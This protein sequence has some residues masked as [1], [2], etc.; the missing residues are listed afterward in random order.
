MIQDDF[1]WYWINNIHGVSREKIKS[2]LNTFETPRDVYNAGEKLLLSVP[3]IGKKSVDSII[4]SKKQE[5]LFLEYSRMKDKGIKITYPGKEDYP[6]KLLNIYDYPYILYYKGKLL[7]DRPAVSVIGARNCTEYGK[8]IA[9]SFSA[10][11]SQMGLGVIS[12]MALG[13]DTQAH[14]GALDAGG[15]TCAVLGCG[16]DVCYPRSNIGM[17]EEIIETGCILSEYPPGT[18]PNP[19][20]FPVRNRIISA[21]SDAVVV[22]EARAKSGSLITVDA[23]MEYNKDVY[24]V[25]GRIG[26]A[27]SEG[28]LI[29]LKEAG[30]IITSPADIFNTNSINS[31][32]NSIKKNDI[33]QNN[34]NEQYN[35]DVAK[36]KFLVYSQINLFPTS[37]EIIIR[38]SGLLTAVVSQFLIE[39]EIEGLIKEVSKNYY[40]RTH[41]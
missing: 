1:Y 26:D 12:G 15:Y 10:A 21:L 32:V 31:Y 18:A 2:L 30:Y 40:V 6:E 13:I 9:R 25:P 34:F 3:D 7:L 19:G 8:S 14:R 11:F 20:Q 5:G 39:L 33:N 22:V 36:D 41:I 4:N 16:V 37:L 17:Y 35:F 38:E 24:F 29:R 28:C 27:L 23:A